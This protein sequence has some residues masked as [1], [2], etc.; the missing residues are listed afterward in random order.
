MNLQLV[1]IAIA[2]I[3]LIGFAITWSLE[4][5]LPAI[6]LGLASIVGAL[7]MLYPKYGL[8]MKVSLVVVAIF[9]AFCVLASINRY[10]QRHAV[11]WA[12]AFWDKL[13]RR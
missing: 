13:R 12:M 8:S 1:G 5:T 9:V 6:V 4:K 7:V 2:G 3:S 11:G 10:L